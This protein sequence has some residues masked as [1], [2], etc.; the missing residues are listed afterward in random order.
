MFILYLVGSYLSRHIF[1]KRV[2]ITIY[3]GAFKGG[4]EGSYSEKHSR[5]A[6]R[7]GFNVSH[8][9]K[10]ETPVLILSPTYTSEPGGSPAF[11]ETFLDMCSP[12]L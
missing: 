7:A 1:N 6:L 11:F 5:L 10:N 4:F 8:A 9:V 2:A 3:C 12:S